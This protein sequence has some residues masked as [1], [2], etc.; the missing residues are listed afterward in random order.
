MQF[1]VCSLLSSDCHFPASHFEQCLW[2]QASVCS[3]LDLCNQLKL[4]LPLNS[5][6]FS[7]AIH[8]YVGRNLLALMFAKCAVQTGC[9]LSVIS[10]K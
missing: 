10:W 5:K 4:V 6:R 9:Q 2:S 3:P 8:I 1:A 7:V